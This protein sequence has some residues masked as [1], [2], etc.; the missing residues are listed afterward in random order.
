MRTYNKE[1][2]KS[3]SVEELKNMLDL[4]KTSSELSKEEIE[5]NVQILESALGSKTQAT[6]VVNM[7]YDGLADTDDFRDSSSFN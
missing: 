4:V 7:C 5:A 3:K 2:L 6:L 1:I